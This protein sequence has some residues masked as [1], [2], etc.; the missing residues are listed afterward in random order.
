MVWFRGG[1]GGGGGGRGSVFYLTFLKILMSHNKYKL[2]MT[3]IE[4]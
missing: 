1:G 3:K 4:S 2:K